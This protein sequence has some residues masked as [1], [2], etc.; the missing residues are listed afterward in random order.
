M[1]QKNQ[2]SHDRTKFSV[3]ARV[4][5]FV[6]AFTGMKNF[7][8]SQHNA[9]IHMLATVVITFLA[10][11]FHISNSEAMA[12]ILA[13]G[14]VWVS[15]LFNTAIENI[16]NFISVERDPRIGII[17]DISAAAVW[18]AAIT[19]LLV[20]CFVFIPKILL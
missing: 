18:V 13:A 9:W 10:V 17:K 15:E 19:A 1:G 20:G 14:F 5:S 2:L 3:R 8:S 6:Y 11:V 7:F 16:M 4:K 12:L